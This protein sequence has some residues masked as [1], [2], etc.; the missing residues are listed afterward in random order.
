MAPSVTLSE[1]ALLEEIESAADHIDPEALAD[2]LMRGD[3]LLVIDVRPAEEYHAYHI[4]GSVNVQLPELTEYLNRTGH[5]GPVVLYSNGMVHPAQ[6]RD[7]LVRLGYQ[8]VYM[9]TDGL[10]GFLQRCLKPVSLRTEPLA[11]AEAARVRAWRSFFLPAGDVGGPTGS[12][13]VGEASEADDV[14]F[15]ENDSPGLV[16]TNWLADHLRDPGLRIVD[17]RTHADYTQGHIPG[18]VYLN[19]ESVRGG[20]GGVPSMLLP[21]DLLAQHLSILGITSSDMVV[22]D[23][24]DSVRDATLISMA[25]QRLG[26]QHWAILHG[27]FP[28]WSAEER[29]VDQVIPAIATTAYQPATNQDLFTVDASYIAERLTDNKTII[30]DTRPKEYFTGESSREMRAGRIP[31]AVNHVYKEDLDAAGNL[32]PVDELAEAY[33]KLIPAKDTPIVV[34]CRTGHQASL[35]FFVLKEMLGYS[36]VKWYD[37]S[38]TDWAARDLPLETG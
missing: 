15:T 22:F 32:K 27:G 30:I 25:L 14:N 18:S 5:N 11:A 31:G 1:Q 37:A 13:V 6:A 28:K 4:P 38:W 3:Q 33:R 12:M 23:P 16:S 24:G 10:Q 21:S 2:A 9:L 19:L 29:P 26:H 7:A 35:T 20:V 34:Y 36:N 17:C 8:N